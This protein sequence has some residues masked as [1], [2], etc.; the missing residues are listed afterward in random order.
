MQE[1]TRVLT[2]VK[3]HLLSRVVKS[4]LDHVYLV[5]KNY[6]YTY[7]LFA[8]EPAKGSVDQRT[9]AIASPSVYFLLG[10]YRLPGAPEGA[11]ECVGP[12]PLSVK[13]LQSIEV[14]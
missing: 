13:A 6:F 4:T 1:S 2:V 12:S 5:V 3:H 10:E 9:A 7:S 11:G 8:G 14:I